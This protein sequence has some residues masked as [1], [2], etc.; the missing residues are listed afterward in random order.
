[1]TKVYVYNYKSLD[2][3][4]KDFKKKVEKAGIIKAFRK[5]HHYIP[6]SQKKQQ[7]VFRKRQLQNKEK[8]G[9]NQWENTF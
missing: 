6:K 5:K 4:L 8:K 2:A 9:Q 3:A 7:A 1:M